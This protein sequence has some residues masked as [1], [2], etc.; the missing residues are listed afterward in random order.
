MTLS[1]SNA[2]SGTI[3]ADL[4][5]EKILEILYGRSIFRPAIVLTPLLPFS[6]PH[7]K[8]GWWSTYDLPPKSARAPGLTVVRTGVGS[9]S[10]TNCLGHLFNTLGPAARLHQYIFFGSVGA[11]EGKVPVA[12][13]RPSS[14][15]LTPASFLAADHEAFLRGRLSILYR[16]PY[17]GASPLLP[18]A[19]LDGLC[20]SVPGSWQGQTLALE[21]RPHGIGFVDQESYWFVSFMNAVRIADYNVFLVTVDSLEQPK[22]S[23]KPDTSALQC[24]FKRLIELLECGAGPENMQLEN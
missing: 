1:I 13:Q 6:L 4:P 22:E 9:E 20:L 2:P 15:P 21:C 14:P 7:Q 16:Q 12:I 10:V 3:P 11:V 18:D 24:V 5:T 17:M 23:L 19:K 8:R